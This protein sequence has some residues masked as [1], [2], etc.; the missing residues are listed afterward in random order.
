MKWL[1]AFGLTF[2]PAAEVAAEQ[3]SAF[4]LD[5]VPTVATSS[6]VAQPQPTPQII[7]DEAVRGTW[8]AGVSY[9][10]REIPVLAVRRDNKR[11]EHDGRLL[12][13]RPFRRRRQRYIGIWLAKFRYGGREILKAS[14][15]PILNQPGPDQIRRIDGIC[16]CIPSA[17]VGYMG[18]KISNRSV[19]DV[20]T[21]RFDQ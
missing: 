15:L 9:N 5:S 8:E 6:P 17:Y 19:R 1:I 16:L 2:I 11:T 12:F 4:T 7:R 21:R 13:A 14:D 18:Y 20:H 3:V 10:V